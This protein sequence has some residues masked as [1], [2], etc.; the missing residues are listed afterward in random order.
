MSFSDTEDDAPTG[1][2][3]DGNYVI[4][5]YPFTFSAQESQYR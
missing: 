3:R 5:F 4:S 2:G 1:A